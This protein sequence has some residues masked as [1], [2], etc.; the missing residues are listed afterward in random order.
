MP[1]TLDNT[2]AP[3]A[4]SARASSYWLAPHVCAA[5][6]PTGL[7]LLDL[8]RN[9]YL[10]LVPSD[11]VAAANLVADLPISAARKDWLNADAAAEAIRSLDQ[12]GLLTRERPARS[13]SVTP[14]IATSSLVS[15]GEELEGGASPNALDVVRFG[16]ACARALF[17]L[18]R[19]TLFDIV[20]ELA[21]AP[22]LVA[23]DELRAIDRAGIFRGIRPYVFSAKDR[24]LFHALALR[25]FLR[26]YGVQSQWILGVRTQ[27]W[28]AHSWVQHGALVLD[29]SPE[30]VCDYEAILAA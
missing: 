21:R 22:D 11:A 14:H 8:K 15:V 12:A 4:P 29:S 18:R 25:Y 19:R 17:A 5:A 6:T 16:Q 28:A 23:Q 20:L 24:C 2:F 30:K 26:D 13:I 7:V 27:P 9:R 1:S 10:G 3:T